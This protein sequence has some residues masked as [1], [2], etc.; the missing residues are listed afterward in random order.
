MAL[1]KT[2]MHLIY[3]KL[4]DDGMVAYDKLVPKNHF[5]DLRAIVPEAYLR[6][7]LM[8]SRLDERANKDQESRAIR[9]IRARPGLAA[10]GAQLP[11]CTIMEP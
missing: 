4:K 7:V 5:G 9:A 11:A 8:R 1:F 2:I 3:Q 6:R 10:R